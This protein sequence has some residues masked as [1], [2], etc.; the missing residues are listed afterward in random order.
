[1]AQFGF[2]DRLNDTLRS[3]MIGFI[4]K[5]KTDAANIHDLKYISRNPPGDGVNAWM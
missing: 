3:E 4:R 2:S 1:M 5:K